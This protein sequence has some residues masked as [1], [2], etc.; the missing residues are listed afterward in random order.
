M[1]QRTNFTPPTLRNYSDKTT[2]EISNEPEIPIQVTVE[3]RKPSIKKR[4]RVH[5]A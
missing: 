3:E 4:P 2:N 1:S 5:G